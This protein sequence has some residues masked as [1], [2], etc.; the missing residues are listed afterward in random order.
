M[1][2]QPSPPIDLKPCPFCNGVAVV[3]PGQ[4][5][6]GSCRVCCVV[7]WVKTREFFQREQAVVAWN[8]RGATTTPASPVPAPALTVGELVE[9]D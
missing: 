6:A 2:D 8:R 3:Q 5:S 1:S 4:L 7:C 9:G